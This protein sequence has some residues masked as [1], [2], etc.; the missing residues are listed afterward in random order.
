MPF[1]PGRTLWSV[2]ANAKLLAGRDKRVRV[3]YLIRRAS[4]ANMVHGVV[5]E[6]AAPF[7]C[8]PVHW[9]G[10][11]KGRSDVSVD[12]ADGAQSHESATEQAGIADAAFRIVLQPH[13]SLSP[14]G[15]VLLMGI[16]CVISFLA[17]IYFVSRGAWPVFGFFGL[18]VALVYG[19]FQLNYR[20]GRLH[21]IVEISP[22]ELRVCRVHPSG[23]EE[24]FS[25]N[26]YWVQ[27]RLIERGDGR[28][29]LMLQHHDKR[30]AFGRFL[31][32]QERREVAGALKDALLTTR[33]GPRI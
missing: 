7:A 8:L 32:D 25:F 27:V 4:D 23:R 14:R 5:E 16:L 19:A 15:F 18:D 20:S 17:G 28:N 3:H 6:W 24:R 1:A 2:G 12:R 13:R 9:S 21:E 33:G 10:N 30:L 29:L 31:T 11:R 22:D 26:P